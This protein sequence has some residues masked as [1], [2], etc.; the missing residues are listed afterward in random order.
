M[1]YQSIHRTAVITPPPPIDAALLDAMLLDDETDDFLD[2][3][4]AAIRESLTDFRDT[5]AL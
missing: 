3:H 5:E 4:V 2:H 1:S